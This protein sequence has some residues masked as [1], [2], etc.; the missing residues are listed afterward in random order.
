MDPDT[1][2]NAHCR[3]IVSFEQHCD[4]ALHL[5]ALA[6]VALGR[7]ARIRHTFS[8][9]DMAFGCRFFANGRRFGVLGGGW[10]SVV[11]RVIES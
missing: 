3:V 2:R 4:E 5:G 11:C 6:V 9:R 1:A 8:D 10:F 7:Y